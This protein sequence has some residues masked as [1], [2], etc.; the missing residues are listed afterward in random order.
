MRFTVGWRALQVRIHEAP[1]F[2]TEVLAR[3]SERPGSRRSEHEAGPFCPACFVLEDWFL[4]SGEKTGQRVRGQEMRGGAASSQEAVFLEACLLYFF[5][6]QCLCM[7]MHTC[8][9]LTSMPM[10]MHAR[11]Q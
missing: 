9:P 11:H 1:F 5:T 7:L 3:L 2:M 10:R 6:A 8:I 4:G